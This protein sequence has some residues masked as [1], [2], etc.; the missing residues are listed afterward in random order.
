MLLMLGGISLVGVVTATMASWIVQRVASEDTEHQAATAAEIDS[1][2]TG[3]E[4]QIAAL[5]D[6]IRSMTGAA[7]RDVGHVDADRDATAQGPRS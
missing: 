4:G 6:E 7:S 3:L 1:L 2:R 5:R